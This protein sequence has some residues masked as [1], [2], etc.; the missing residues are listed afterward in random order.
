LW[1]AVKRAIVRID[2]Q[3]WLVGWLVVVED[4][5]ETAGCRDDHQYNA[6]GYDTMEPYMATHCPTRTNMHATIYFL[7]TDNN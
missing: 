4:E 6:K 2:V 1:L 7:L 5:T 3:T